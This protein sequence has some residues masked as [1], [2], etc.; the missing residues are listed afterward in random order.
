MTVDI[1]SAGE[2]EA[3]QVFAGRIDILYALGRHYLSLPFAVLCVPVTLLSGNAPGVLPLMPLL[4][5]IIV[6]ICAEQL[7]TAYRGRP[8]GS[9]PHYWAR[10]YTFVSGI[11]GATWGVGAVFWF[12]WGSFPAQAYLALAY[13]GMTATEFIARSAH[14]PAFAAHTGFS[15]LPL[16]FMLLYQG[17]L[18]ATM[19]GL[20]VGFFGAVLVS[21][22]KGMGRLLNESV[23][24]RNVN[25]QL[26]VRLSGEKAEAIAARDAARASAH[27]KSSFIANISHELR[28]P[29][30]ALLG[31]AQLLERA[32]LPRAQAGH[33]KVML[34][35]G[36]GLQ[37]LIDDVIALTRDE[38]EQ[39]EDE[40][41]DPV[42]A[43]RAVVRLA[44]PRAWEKRLRLNL[45]VAPGLPRVA[46]DPRRVRQVLLK[47]I[48][49]ALKFT[50]R[51]LVDIRLDA[52]QDD[53]GR[54]IVCFSVTDTG[55]GVTPEAARHLFSPFAPGDSSYA[56]KE[57]GAGLGLAVA[58][59]IVEQAGGSI[60]FDSTPGEGAQ[61]VFT[62]PASG[63]VERAETNMEA[64]QQ[65]PPTG[66]S[67]LLY[68]TAPDIAAGL[69]HLLEPF[70]NRTRIAA[71]LADAVALATQ[72]PF[73]AIIAGAGDADM[74]AVAPGNQ[75]PIIAVLL[76]GERAPSSTDTV[77]R[78]PVQ[79]DTL[80][81]ALE[82]V[83][84]GKENPDAAHE[85]VAPI[86]AT[87]FS[88][89]EKSVGV[90]ALHDILQCYITTAEQ[91]TQALADACA[92]DKWD[93]ASRLAQDIVGAAG[94]LGLAAVTQAARHFT[95][96]TR[97]G[98]NP[99]ELR[100]AAQ[101]VLGEHI[102]TKQALTH[103][104]PDVM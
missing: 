48:D 26:V 79:A 103:L 50:E 25:S 92:E 16:I 63:A 39:L 2:D 37:I 14:R 87:A 68:S 61:F 3:R 81:Q 104:Y 85:P 28:T 36:R 38:S 33:V 100:N 12:V 80:Y 19:T 53:Q 83:C 13:L 82:Q 84:G 52:G 62:L 89:L 64:G 54:A 32:E 21:Y 9:D 1:T 91:L 47:L 31:M 49:N 45:S 98:E 43:V 51:G 55:P 27:A 90:K 56:R 29:L 8:A 69:A 93:D 60:T 23:H 10:R 77:L 57:Q 20:L 17:G 102:R 74:L 94:G 40:D 34:E 58:K 44:Q 95:Q 18:Y 35:A 73:D 15:L 67:V 7:T 99:H 42:Q 96:A 59:R 30:N 88:T 41:C 86:D 4:L 5:Q 75:S 71:T 70:G 76:R 11:A 24:L 97:A 65:Q 101:I 6:V 46:A 22:C 66:L 72:E 78:W